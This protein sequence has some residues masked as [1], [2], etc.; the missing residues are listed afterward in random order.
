MPIPDLSFDLNLGVTSMKFS[1]KDIKFTDLSA[2]KA[3]LE[4]AGEELVTCSLEGCDVMLTLL[5]EF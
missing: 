5:W 3:Y 2:R 4:F 1:L